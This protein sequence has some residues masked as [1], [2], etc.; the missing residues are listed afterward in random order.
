MIASATK[1][2]GSF[3]D[4][5]WFEESRHM[6]SIPSPASMQ[7]RQHLF[8]TSRIAFRLCSTP[9]LRTV[10]KLGTRPGFLTMNAISSAGSPPRLKNSRPKSSTKDLEVGCVAIRTRCPNFFSAR[11]REMNGC[12][13]PREPMIWMTTFNLVMGIPIASPASTENGG[14][15]SVSSWPSF[16]KAGAK[17][18]ESLRALESILMSMRPSSI[19]NVSVQS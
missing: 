14:T 16:C 3:C 4:S 7:E 5:N 1:G 11:A 12:T 8:K 15:D 2:F 18:A 19:Q 6:E 17:S 9:P 13:S 10:S